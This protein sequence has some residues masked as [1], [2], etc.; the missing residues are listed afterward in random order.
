MINEGYEK[1]KQAIIDL[2]LNDYKTKY[3]KRSVNTAISKCL[4]KKKI[5]IKNNH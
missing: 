5:N 3:L 4:V 1:T 2:R